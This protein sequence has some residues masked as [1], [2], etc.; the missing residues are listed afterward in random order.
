MKGRAL[1]TPGLVGIMLL[2][3]CGTRD[4][5]RHRKGPL[6]ARAVQLQCALRPFHPLVPFARGL[7]QS[8]HAVV[9][10]TRAA[11]APTVQRA[12]FRHSPA[13]LD[14]AINEVYPQIRTMPASELMAFMHPQVWCGLLP[15]H[16][17]PD[18]LA[19]A[20]RW[21]PDLVVRE[22]RDYAGCIAAEVLGVPHASVD[23]HATLDREYPQWATQPLNRHRAAVG[24]P[25][26][27]ALAMLRRYL[28]LRPFP[29]SF[30]DPAHTISPTTHH[31]R[32][33]PDD[34][35]GAE[36][37]PD[38]AASLPDRPVVYVGM[39]TT[40]NKPEVF[41]AFIAGLRDEALTLVVTVGRDQDPAD[42]GPQPGNVHI[43]RYI[44]LSLL[45]PRC[46]VVVTNGGSGT[47]MAALSHG[48]PVVVVPISADQPD[49]AAR[50]RALGL[51]RVVQP[52]ELTPEWARQAVRSVRAEPSYRRNAER[53]RDEIAALP[54]VDYAVAL[55]ERLGVEKR[56]I[57][58]G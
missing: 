13:G 35:S 57:L 9:F 46:D 2:S 38:W 27:P 53:L 15:E 11:F 51:G 30:P 12:G 26:D 24:L 31:V 7:E 50:C 36:G 3:A 34:R 5:P 39:G 58:A 52:A 32:P 42:Y 14:R 23:V 55:L 44:P 1:R 28:A 25:P 18:L 20:E 48:L 49:N 4:A 41:R 37:L 40:F 10:A 43:E 45:L 17:V 8:G 22:E 16:K 33:T 19:L 29:Q 21:P 6:Y 54:G 47:L 56:P